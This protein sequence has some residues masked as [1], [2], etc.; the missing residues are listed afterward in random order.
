MNTSF[1]NAQYPCCTFRG[2]VVALDIE[3][4]KQLWKSYANPDPPGP[5]R[6]NEAGHGALG[7]MAGNVLLAF[8]PE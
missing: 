8:A 5:T 6:A 7:G 1:V 3:N 2:S 4:G